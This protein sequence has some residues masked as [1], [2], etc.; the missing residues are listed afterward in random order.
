MG[1]ADKLISAWLIISL[2]WPDRFIS[3]FIY[4]QKCCGRGTERIS[5][6]LECACQDGLQHAAPLQE[7]A[8]S[9]QLPAMRGLSM[10]VF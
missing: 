8:L 6:K 7:I 10:R 3:F 2:A 4:G 5:Y 9:L 1:G